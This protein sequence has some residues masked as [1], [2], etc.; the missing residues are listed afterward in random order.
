FTLL[1]ECVACT[2]LGLIVWLAI[3]YTVRYT[4]KLLLMYKGWIYEQRGKGRVISNRTKIWLLFVKILSGGSKPLLYSFQG[5]LPRLPLPSLQDTMKRVSYICG[6]FSNDKK[7]YL[8]SVRPLLSDEK[9]TRMQK[10][11]EEFE[12]GIGAKL[13]RY[14]VLK[15]W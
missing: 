10:L 3:I 7:N 4:L 5:S 2:L 6:D 9:F 1:W 15:S 11:A 8:R 13:Q 14:L 12:R